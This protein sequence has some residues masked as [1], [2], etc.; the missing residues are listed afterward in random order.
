MIRVHVR[1]PARCRQAAAAGRFRHALTHR[2]G[3][4]RAV[5]IRRLRR[6][7]RALERQAPQD[8]HPR[9]ARPRDR[10]SGA[11]RRNRQEH[12]DQLAGGGRPIRACRPGCS[13]C[14]PGKR[15]G[16]RPH[17]ELAV[18]DAHGHIRH[19]HQRRH[20]PSQGNAQRRC[21]PARARLGRS[22]LR[23]RDL[24]DP[25]QRVPDAHARQRRA[26]DHRCRGEVAPQLPDRGDRR[27]EHGPRDRAELR[28]QPRQGRDHV[29][30]THPDDSDLRLRRVGGSRSAAAARHHRRGGH[31][32][33][34]GAAQPD[35]PGG[36]DDQQRDPA[37]RPRRR[38]RLLALLPQAGARGARTRSHQRS[39]DRGRSRN[40]GPCCSRL[41][42]HG[43]DRDGRHV[44]RRIADLRLS[45]D[46]HD[47]RRRGFRARIAVGAARSAVGPRRSRGAGPDPVPAPPQARAG[48][49]DAHHRRAFCAGP[50]SRR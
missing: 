22:A 20:R 2:K 15:G 24:L 30:A 6:P 44:P 17:P 9:L 35:H 12:A 13:R 7:R 29:A 1:V 28:A 37:D 32:R 47:S 50:P 8:R 38:S 33:S 45:R 42:P 19:R 49:L 26:G 41:G 43:D 14:V 10:R 25:G 39:R 31:A 23:A 48:N 3:A 4:P 11:R 18:H 5:L 36:P 46:R 40:F 34:R 27:R 21:G 16:D